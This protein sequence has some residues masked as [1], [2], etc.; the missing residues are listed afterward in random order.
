MKDKPIEP[1]DWRTRVPEET[2]LF[3]DTKGSF[4]VVIKAINGLIDK[5]NELIDEVNEL[6]RVMKELKRGDSNE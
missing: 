5:I 3:R 1:I 2:G 4:Q 6:K